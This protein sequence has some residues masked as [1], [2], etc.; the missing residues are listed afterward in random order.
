MHRSPKAYP[1]IV[2]LS[3]I[4]VEVMCL[5]IF[6][7]TQPDKIWA[8][9][10]PREVGYQEGKPKVNHVTLK[11]SELQLN[12]TTLTYFGTLLEEAALA[13]VSEYLDEMLKY[14]EFCAH[15]VMIP[16]K[17]Y[18][19]GTPGG[20]AAMNLYFKQLKYSISQTLSAMDEYSDEDLWKLAY[21]FAVYYINVK[22][23]PH[24]FNH[25]LDAHAKSDLFSI[26]EY[27]MVTNLLYKPSWD[28]SRESITNSY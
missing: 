2:R 25:E 12:N 18:L 19:H 16:M 15:V 26:L 22:N 28:K 5:A 4:L 10:T 24:P 1:E 21:V 27:G 13:T 17:K 8:Q 14:F 6:P 3:V 11:A 20:Q 23:Y 9:A 7:E